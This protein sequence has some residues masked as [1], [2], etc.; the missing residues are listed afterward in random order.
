MKYVFFIIV[1]F[2]VYA[3]LSPAPGITAG[4]CLSS[5]GWVQT[6]DNGNQ[7]CQLPGGHVEW[8]HK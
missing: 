2:F 3:A 1:L 5:G 4:K 8:V 7:Y 6:F